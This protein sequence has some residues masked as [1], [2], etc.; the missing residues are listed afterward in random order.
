MIGGRGALSCG[1]AGLFRL[2]GVSDVT[3]LADTSPVQTAATADAAPDGAQA[4]IGKTVADHPVVLF[5]KGVPDQPRCGF[6]AVVVQILDH[7]GAQFVGVDV[8][9][10]PS[11]REGVKAYSD[12]PTIPQLYVQ[13]EFVGGS[14]ILREMFTTGELKTLLQGKGVLAA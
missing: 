13:G 7:L 14:D 9:Q 4:F 3:D 1:L 6:S 8:L 12:W 2:F 10:D 11:L 5:M